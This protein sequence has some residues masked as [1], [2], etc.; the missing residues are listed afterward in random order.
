MVVPPC[1]TTR[2][3]LRLRAWVLDVEFQG[4]SK[5]PVPKVRKL[6]IDQIPII[7]RIFHGL[8]TPLIQLSFKS[9]QLGDSAGCCVEGIFGT[10]YC[11]SVLALLTQQ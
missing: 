8:K 6:D 11:S 4:D 3:E 1:Q 9:G 10:F 7:Y 2:A 5:R